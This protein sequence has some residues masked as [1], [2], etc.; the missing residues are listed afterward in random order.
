MFRGLSVNRGLTL[1]RLLT[2]LCVLHFEE[3]RRIASTRK[4]DVIEYVC[5]LF[6]LKISS[7]KEFHLY[8]VHI[9]I[10]NIKKIQTTG[11]KES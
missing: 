2:E 9:Y 7:W 10:E 6:F 8:I 11:L 1:V 4:H 5:I 3:N